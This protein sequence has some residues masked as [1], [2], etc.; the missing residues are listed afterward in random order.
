MK[1]FAKGKLTAVLFAIA[2]TLAVSA[3]A[4]AAWP[5]FQNDYLNT[6]QIIVPSG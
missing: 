3:A 1:K 5:S 6:G 2:L 4:F